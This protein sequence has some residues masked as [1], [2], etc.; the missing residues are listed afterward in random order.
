MFFRVSANFKLRLDCL[1]ETHKIYE[2]LS[3]LELRSNN[4]GL[5]SLVF[6]ISVFGRHPR[7][8]LFE[9]FSKFNES[10]CKALGNFRKTFD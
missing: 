5:V 4:V 6:N 3:V 7:Y 10:F 2:S 1:I 9:G 8:E